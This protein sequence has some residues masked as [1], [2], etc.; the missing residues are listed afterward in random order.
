MLQARAPPAGPKLCRSA[1][2]QP[3]CE[4]GLSVAFLTPRDYHSCDT[5]EI[6]NSLVWGKAELNPQVCS[7]RA[8]KKTTAQSGAY[9]PHP[10]PCKLKS[11]I[12]PLSSPGHS[13]LPTSHLPCPPHGHHNSIANTSATEPSALFPTLGGP[14]APSGSSSPIAQQLPSNPQPWEDLC[15]RL[16]VDRGLPFSPPP[17]HY[18]LVHS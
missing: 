1:P 18:E 9:N 15:S 5:Q 12:G 7:F 3:K 10:H 16:E 2:T 6:L 14:A 8:W 13:V 11:G 17:S 4:A